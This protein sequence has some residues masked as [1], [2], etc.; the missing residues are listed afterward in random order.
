M[1]D[2][3]RFLAGLGSLAIGSGALYQ[4]GAFSTV[5]GD[6]GVGVQTAADP[7]AI[8]GME[9]LSD[10]S[11]DNIFTNNS[12]YDMEI[13]LDAIE[14]GIEWDINDPVND[15]DNDTDPVTFTLSPDESATVYVKGD[16]AVTFDGTAVLRESGVESGRVTFQRT[17][18]VPV[19]NNLELSGSVS[20]AGNSG[21][22]EFTLENTGSV[23]VELLEIGI[24]ET[25]ANSDRVS[26]GGSL[27]NVDT[28]TEY[29]TD[30]I[31]IDSTTST[32]TL[33]SLSPTPILYSK[34]N[35]NTSITFEFRKFLRANG[36][37]GPPQVDM[38]GEDVKIEVKIKNK[39]DGTVSKAPV[40]L[41]SGGCNF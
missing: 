9:G 32:S 13:T 25:T 2:R 22:F 7:N 37:N 40:S 35:G 38:R 31:P 12:S 33:K 26:G 6:R 41:C 19:V 10:P 15:S 28:G 36:G 20:S 23:D 16:D 18:D 34:N 29:I 27:F 39:S 24:I 1:V 21:K 11:K 5:R 8:V 4:S 30:A 17:I 3:R 14:S